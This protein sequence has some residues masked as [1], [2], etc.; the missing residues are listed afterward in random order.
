MREHVVV[1]RWSERREDEPAK[2]VPPPGTFYVEH[3]LLCRCGEVFVSRH[4]RTTRSLLR[5]HRAQQLAI[6]KAGGNVTSTQLYNRAPL[7][8]MRSSPTKAHQR[9]ER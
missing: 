2:G 6:K 1:K 7:T 4:A 8:A 5:V 9:Y 3:C